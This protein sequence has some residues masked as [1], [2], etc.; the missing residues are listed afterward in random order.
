MHQRHS[1]SSVMRN[2]DGIDGWD[3]VSQMVVGMYAAL[4]EILSNPA[5]GVRLRN[6]AC[7]WFVKGEER[8]FSYSFWLL[9]GRIHIISFF[10]RTALLEN[11]VT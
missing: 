10:L 4:I 1:K 5:D 6:M 7:L 8:V 3:D 9:K 2:C 11:M